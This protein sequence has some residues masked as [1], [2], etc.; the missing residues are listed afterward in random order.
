ESGR[1]ETTASV[2]LANRRQAG[3]VMKRVSEL[4]RRAAHLAAADE[5]KA[6]EQRYKLLAGFDVD[7]LNSRASLSVP[8]AQR[9]G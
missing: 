2:Q 9:A 4:A 8:A 1:R 6:V 7:T 3:D 5:L